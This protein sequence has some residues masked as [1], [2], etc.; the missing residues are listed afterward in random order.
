[1]IEDYRNISG[2]LEHKLK[3]HKLWNSNIQKQMFMNLIANI[4]LSNHEFNEIVE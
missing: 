3:Y 2:L 4:L 1:M